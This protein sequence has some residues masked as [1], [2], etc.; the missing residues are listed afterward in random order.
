MPLYDATVPQLSKMLGNLDGWL[1]KAAAFADSRKADPER[2]VQA[3]LA[4][5]QYALAQQ[6][7]GAC[8]TAKFA[9]ARM[10]GK[11][12]PKDADDEKT[13]AEL[14]ARIAKTREYL[15]SFEPSDFDGAEERV[16]ALPFLP[17]KGALA[18]EYLNS[19]ALPNCYFHLCMAY[20]ILR[21][22]GVELGKR[23]YIGSIDIQDL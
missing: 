8:D 1:E 9:A 17:G 22:N 2:W 13:L 20:A 11:E 19:W 21:T 23:D 14:H 16:V 5:D 15:A 18:G 4:I 3:R 7:Q 12:A 6:V 10:T